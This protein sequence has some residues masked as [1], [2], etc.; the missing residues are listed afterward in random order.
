MYHKIQGKI[1]KMLV[2]QH[3]SAE[4]R[5]LSL[6]PLQIAK[7]PLQKEGLGYVT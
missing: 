1:T 2:R 7:N 6:Y 3:L 4:F 5:L